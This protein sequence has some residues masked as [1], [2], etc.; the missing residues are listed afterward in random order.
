MQGQHRCQRLYESQ[1][2][3]ATVDA[4][5]HFRTLPGLYGKSP[6]EARLRGRSPIDQRRKKLTAL[7]PELDIQGDAAI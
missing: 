6:V 3:R 4:R 1:D 2:R 5:C 7:M